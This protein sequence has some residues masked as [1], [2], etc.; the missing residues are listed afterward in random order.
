MLGCVMLYAIVCKKLKCTLGLLKKS[1]DY[2]LQ[3]R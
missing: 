1:I 2:I 3:P